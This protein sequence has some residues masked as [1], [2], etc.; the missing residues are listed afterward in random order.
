MKLEAVCGAVFTTVRKDK[1]DIVSLCVLADNTLAIALNNKF[2]KL[3]NTSSST[4]SSTYI[5]GDEDSWDLTK[6]SDGE[7]DDGEENDNDD[8]TDD[9]TAADAADSEE[10]NQKH[11]CCFANT[12]GTSTWDGFLMIEL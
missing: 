4:L 1:C 8:D 2:I 3:L 11:K 5:G 9:A 6:M 12:M 7:D 10:Q